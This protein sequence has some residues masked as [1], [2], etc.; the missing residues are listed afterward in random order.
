[1]S[2]L[3][4]KIG[5]MISQPNDIDFET[6]DSVLRGIGCKV[7]NPGGSH[8]VYIHPNVTLPLSVPKAKPIK[9]CYIIQAIKL[10][11]LQEKYNEIN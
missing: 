10:F 4:K 6:L 5:K 9:N 2:A 1:M 8:Y 3:K 11:G 7:R